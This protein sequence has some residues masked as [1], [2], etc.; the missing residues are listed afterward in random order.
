MTK[1]RQQQEPFEGEASCYYCGKIVNDSEEKTYIYVTSLDM[2]R[3]R[4]PIHQR[5]L[6]RY[7]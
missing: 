4:K 2:G 3:E 5:C 7:T 6:R 1:E